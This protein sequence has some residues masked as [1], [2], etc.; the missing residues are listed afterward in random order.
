MLVERENKDSLVLWGMTMGTT[1]AC[2]IIMRGIVLIL[3]MCE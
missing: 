2:C 3:G 1:R